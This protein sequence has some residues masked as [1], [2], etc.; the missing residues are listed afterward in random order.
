MFHDVILSGGF[1]LIALSVQISKITRSSCVPKESGFKML[2]ILDGPYPVVKI[3]NFMELVSSNEKAVNHSD[4]FFLSRQ[5]RLSPESYNLLLPLWASF[6]GQKSRSNIKLLKSLSRFSHDVP[7]HVMTLFFASCPWGMKGLK[8][9]H[10][11][12]W[13]N[14]NPHN[15]TWINILA[16]LEAEIARKQARSE[17]PPAGTAVH[18]VIPSRSLKPEAA[19]AS[20]AANKTVLD[21]EQQLLEE[22]MKVEG[23]TLEKLRQKEEASSARQKTQDESTRRRL[24]DTE[25]RLNMEIDQLKSQSQQMEKRYSEVHQQNKE[26]WHLVNQVLAGQM[27]NLNLEG[28]GTGDDKLDPQEQQK[29]DNA[30]KQS[31][32]ELHQRELKRRSM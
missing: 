13:H 14:K 6:N 16:Y 27:K 2:T 31:E 29:Q 8:S 1:F 26:L 5:L 7:T 15:Y 24:Q 10:N 19:L 18:P 23:H 30:K 11:Q 3:N 9:I 17:T 21:A 4:S 20:L 12:I 25:D 32:E 22:S 28:P